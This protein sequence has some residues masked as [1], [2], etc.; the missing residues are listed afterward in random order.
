MQAFFTNTASATSW[1]TRHLPVLSALYESLID[2]DDEVREAA[3][4]AASSLIGT[5][6]VA[7]TAAD[8]LVPWLR[9]HFGESEEFRARVVCRM[10]GQPYS[11]DVR[12]V[13]A[14]EQLRKAM[15]F[16]D[17]LFAAEDQNLFIDEVR[18]AVRW[19]GALVVDSSGGETGSSSS[20]VGCLKEWVEAGLGCLIG[21]AERED[22]PLGWTSDQHVF[23]ICARVLVCAVAVAGT[24]KQTGVAELLREFRAV[25]A[26]SGIHG[27][28]LAMA[29][30][31]TVVA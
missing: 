14:E 5:T 13:P 9:E 4:L 1:D 24:G 30:L 3:A 7:P 25:G 26:R 16:D 29:G 12:L 31:E 2:D 6:A 17:S 10:V 18:E 22:G 23:A 8:G 27:S 20:S 11:A 19:R 21:L 15:E 28:L